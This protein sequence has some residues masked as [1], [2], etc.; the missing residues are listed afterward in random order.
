MV[1]PF[2]DT[3]EFFQEWMKAVQASLLHY[4]STDEYPRHHLCSEG[5]TTW[6][7]WQAKAKRNT[8]TLKRTPLPA[9]I[10]KLLQPIYN[11]LGS[12]MLLERCLGGYT[13]NPN[14]SLRS[15]V[16]KLCPKEFILGRMAGC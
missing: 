10:M 2:E 4:N 9:L 16:W 11:R 13:Q 3:L 14:E 12:A 1:M 8:N 15:T 7:K 5:E 6:C